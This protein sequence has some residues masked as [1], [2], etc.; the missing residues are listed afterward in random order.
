MV[1]ITIVSNTYSSIENH[2]SVK[3]RLP[4]WC[5]EKHEIY[6]FEWQ[7]VYSW[8]YLGTKTKK[9]I[10]HELDLPKLH[11]PNFYP[12]SPWIGVKS[13]IVS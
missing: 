11:I 12:L 9:I 8:L 4:K 6:H 13:K 10:C 7:P 3:K 1:I 2:G 5:H